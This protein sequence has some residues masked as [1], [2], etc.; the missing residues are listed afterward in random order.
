MTCC[1]QTSFVGRIL[2]QPNGKL[3]RFL[4]ATN[5]MKNQFVPHMPPILKIVE[6]GKARKS[7]FLFDF[8]G[9]AVDPSLGQ[10]LS[11]AHNAS[12]AFVSAKP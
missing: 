9:E 2:H 11:T 8:N 10:S 1:V 5:G 7:Y 3:E 6:F 12:C 4:T